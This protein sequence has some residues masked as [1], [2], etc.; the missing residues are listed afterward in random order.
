MA[1]VCHVINAHYDVWRADMA[2]MAARRHTLLLK[3]CHVYR[4]EQHVIGYW[5]ML[6]WRQIAVT[7]V[8]A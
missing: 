8:E 7:V 5:L 3:D 1:N 4:W 2:I 6:I